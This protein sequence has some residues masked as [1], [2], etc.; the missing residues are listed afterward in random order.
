M[1]INFQPIERADPNGYFER[2]CLIFYA[3]ADGKAVKCVVSREV[4]GGRTAGPATIDEAIERYKERQAEIEGT[5]RKIIEEGA[6]TN[7]EAFL[8]QFTRLP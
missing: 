5:L 1:Q 4:L 2:E 8:S 7:G 3:N 6:L